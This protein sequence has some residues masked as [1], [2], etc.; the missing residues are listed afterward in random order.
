MNEKDLIMNDYYIF[1]WLFGAHTYINLIMM[2]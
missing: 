1:S 2:R